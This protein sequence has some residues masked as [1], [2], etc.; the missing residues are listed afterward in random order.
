M[1]TDRI[2]SYRIGG[3]LAGQDAAPPARLGATRP[4]CRRQGF[5]TEQFSLDILAHTAWEAFRNK[6]RDWVCEKSLSKILISHGVG[7]NSIGESAEKLGVDGAR[8]CCH[9]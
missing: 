3:R 2:A 4:G 7:N 6:C 5:P 1:R 9:G 8:I